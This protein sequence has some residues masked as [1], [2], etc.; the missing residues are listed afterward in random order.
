VD[1]LIQDEAENPRLPKRT[2]RNQRASSPNVRRE[3]GGYVVDCD[4]LE[5]SAGC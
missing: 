3:L 5:S 1:G 2:D 4:E